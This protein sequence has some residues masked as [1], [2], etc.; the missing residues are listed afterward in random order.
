[1]YTAA[2]EICLVDGGDDGCRVCFF[3][4]LP[5][6][7]PVAPLTYSNQLRVLVNTEIF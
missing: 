2:T 3:S 5:V 6:Y 7:S 1:M 4:Y